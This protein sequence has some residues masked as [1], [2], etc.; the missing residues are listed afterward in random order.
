M[1]VCSWSFIVTQEQKP[2]LSRRRGRSRLEPATS[3]GVPRK[4]NE[5]PK[6]SQTS[7]THKD[8]AH[9]SRGTAPPWRTLDHW[10][11]NSLNCL[12][13]CLTT[14]LVQATASVCRE[15]AGQQHACNAPLTGV[16]IRPSTDTHASQKCTNLLIVL[17]RAAQ[18]GE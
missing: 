3:R 2:G 17:N 13:T 8:R 11:V 9:H 10:L 4:P 7:K 1:V 18:F 16:P 5:R 14:P 6:S 12:T 15:T